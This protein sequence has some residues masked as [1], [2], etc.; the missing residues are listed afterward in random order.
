MMKSFL[1]KAVKEQWDGIVLYPPRLVSSKAGLER[2]LCAY[3]NINRL[4]IQINTR[5]STSSET[6]L[7]SGTIYHMNYYQTNDRLLVGG[8]VPGAN[9]KLNV[10]T[11]QWG[12]NLDHQSIDND[13]NVIRAMRDRLIQQM[14]P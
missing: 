1:A 9:D 6:R 8:P 14:K 11:T 5:P 13:V 3:K 2:G 7:P 10:N 4:A 12:R